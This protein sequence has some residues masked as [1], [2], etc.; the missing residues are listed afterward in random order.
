MPISNIG[1]PVTPIAFNNLIG[2]NA[3]ALKREFDR[4]VSIKTWLDVH[5]PT[6]SPAVD[7]LTEEPFSYTAE[8]AAVIR[9][10][11]AD[12]AYMKGA[13][14]DSSAF[15]KQLWGVGEVL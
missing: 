6:G 10:A 13:A 7:P 1:Q 4:A 2:G 15:V 12:L 5:P 3:L 14:F 8:Q 11:Y 9:S